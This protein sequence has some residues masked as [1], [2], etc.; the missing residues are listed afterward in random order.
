M[1]PLAILI[2]I[3]LSLF[4]LVVGYYVRKIIAEAKISGARN[5]AEQI[6]GDAKRDAEALKKPFL[7]QGR[8]SYASDRS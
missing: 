5:A 1:S 8:D 7:K 3:L 6:L 2:S 4:C